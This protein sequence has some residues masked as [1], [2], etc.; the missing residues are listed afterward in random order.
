MMTFLTKNLSI[1][2][3]HGHV[4]LSVDYEYDDADDA[5]DAATDEKDAAG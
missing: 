3:H 4:V 1:L 5:G 2:D